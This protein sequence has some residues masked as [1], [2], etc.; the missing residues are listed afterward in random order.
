MDNSSNKESTPPGMKECSKP[1]CHTFLAINDKKACPKCRE[2]DRKNQKAKKLR[3]ATALPPAPAESCIKRKASGMDDRPTT[4]RRT[5]D[6]SLDSDDESDDGGKGKAPKPF[7]QAES[8]FDSLREDFDS[9]QR[10]DFYGTYSVAVDPL[11][12]PKERVQ[13]VAAEI[14]K[15]TGYR[16]TVK[17][18]RTLKGGHRTRLWCC[19]DEARKR[20]SKVSHDPNIRNRNNVGMERYPC[21][22][23]LVISC[24]T[25]RN[26]ED[27]LNMTVQLKHAQKHTSYTNV[28]AMHSS[29]ASTTARERQIMDPAYAQSSSPVSDPTNLQPDSVAERLTAS[30]VRAFLAASE[31]VDIDPES[32][33]ELVQVLLLEAADNSS[34]IVDPVRD[35][36]DSDGG[37]DLEVSELDISA[38]YHV[39]DQVD[40]ETW[41]HQQRRSMLHHLKEHGMSSWVNEYILK[42]NHSIPHLL[43]AFG[44]KLVGPAISK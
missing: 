32:V 44:I 13:M 23:K 9:G 41:T 35:G 6:V 36:V 2:A 7:T 33:E 12:T 5:D 37:F 10:V 40:P 30:Q 26:N 20:K 3:D 11:V 38:L 1:W 31:D 39:Q 29:S 19:Q 16:F 42:R 21:Q 43:L 17:D 27:E 22:S 28:T 8:F 14:W 15:I 25:S 34:G 24:R 18:N 4:R